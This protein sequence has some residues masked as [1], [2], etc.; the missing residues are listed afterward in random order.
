LILKELGGWKTWRER[1]VVRDAY[2]GAG[3]FEQ[4]YVLRDHLGNTRVSFKDVGN[5]GVI[6]TADIKQVNHY[7]P[8]GLNMEGNWQG[9][10]YGQNKY[11]YNGKEWND[12][13]GLGWNDYGFRM[14]DPEIGRWSVIDALSEKYSGYS[15]YN[16]VKNNPVRNIDLLGLGS[17]DLVDDGAADRKSIWE[18]IKESKHYLPPNVI[19]NKSGGKNSDDWYKGSNGRVQWFDHLHTSFKDKNE[20]TWTNIGTTF[21]LSVMTGE[22]DAKYIRGDE[23]GNIW[24]LMKDVEVSDSPIDDSHPLEKADQ[25]QKGAGAGNDMLNI[26]HTLV[27]LSRS[28]GPI[29]GVLGTAGDLIGV[30]NSVRKFSQNPTVGRGINVVIDALLA[31][32]GGGKIKAIDNVLDIAG[33]KD[34]VINYIDRN[35]EMMQDYSYRSKNHKIK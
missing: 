7:Y 20:V 22:N 34:A 9:G 13:F 12:D 28:E 31:R 32:Y 5:D 29:I 6:N 23:Y 3:V 27:G 14:Y 24:D 33:A 35:I 19:A 17:K 15:Q 25:V 1:G 18:K 30:M 26:A 10:L 21:E 11:Q 4:E 16:Y 8:F 2:S